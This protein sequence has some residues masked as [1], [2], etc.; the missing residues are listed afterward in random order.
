MDLY[1]LVKDMKNQPLKVIVNR[2][3][4]IAINRIRLFSKEITQIKPDFLYVLQYSQLS[5]LNLNTEGNF[6]CTLD[7]SESSAT[8]D[9]P[10]SN[11]IL[12]NKK[13]TPEALCK[14]LDEILSDGRKF[15]SYSK[16]LHDLLSRN[17]GIDEIFDAAYRF[18]GNPITLET[19]AGKILYYTKDE[20]LDEIVKKEMLIAEKE[21]L[22]DWFLSQYSRF[23]KDRMTERINNSESPVYSTPSKGYPFITVRV[24]VDRKVIAYVSVFGSEHSLTR[25]DY[26][27]VS[28][29]GS[30]ASYELQKWNYCNDSE[31]MGFDSLIHDILNQHIHDP[32]IIEDRMRAARLELK[33]YTYVL[34]FT[35]DKEEQAN[36]RLPYLVKRITEI[37]KENKAVVY[38]DSIIM[39]ITRDKD[40]PLRKN[41]LNSFN[42]FPSEPRLYVGISAHFEHFWD[43]YKYYLQALKS[44]KIGQYLHKEKTIYPYEEYGL[45]QILDICSG[46]EDILNFCHQAMIDLSIHDRKNGTKLAYTLYVYLKNMQN[47]LE[48]SNELK[49]YRSTLVRHINLIKQIANVDLSDE[50][51]SF[52]LKLTYKILEYVGYA[53]T[54]K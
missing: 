28:L 31:G 11:L 6:A 23:K 50:N 25:I 48:T 36:T 41:D 52:H 32:L 45:Y 34:V 54:K 29:L 51:I 20:N 3:E 17:K 24:T 38:Q 19:V 26:K 53:K 44:L 49:I 22:D 40:N 9:M 42:A 15:E 21:S 12:I 4:N 37:V 13:K 47:Q 2:Q 5:S 46:T 27:L 33:D 16:K 39:I 1:E 14:E 35:V 18:S 8:T 30:I 10:H 43:L 7:C